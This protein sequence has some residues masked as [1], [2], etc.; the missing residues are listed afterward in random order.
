[1]KACF[2]ILALALAL[3]AAS[4]LQA[5]GLVA[6][7]SGKAYVKLSSKSTYQV[8]PV[9]AQLSNGTTVKV[10]PGSSVLLYCS[11][12]DQQTLTEAIQ[13]VTCASTASTLFS[14]GDRQLPAPRSKRR[15]LL[16]AATVLLDERPSI[17]WI[18]GTGTGSVRVMLRGSGMSWERVVAD[19]GELAYPSDAPPLQPGQA[20]RFLVLDPGE[21]PSLASGPL[22]SGVKVLS[23]S[24][25]NVLR[26]LL[27]QLA[28]DDNLSSA[29][30]IHVR[31]RTQL[32]AG[33]NAETI[34]LLEPAAKS[35][36]D[37]A[38]GAALLGRAWLQ[39]GCISCALPIL[40][41]AYQLSTESGEAYLA[42][43][44]GELLGL[45]YRQSGRLRDAL[46][47]EAALREASGQ[48]T[49]CSSAR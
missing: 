24:D 43:E 9:G 1:M 39:S 37:G 29:E 38:M 11:E 49:S 23:R 33:L 22:N 12:T 7:I 30:R 15:L 48:C 2:Y 5:A 21:D 13:I 8:L 27:A 14:W 45:A 10:D 44:S 19:T 28:A 34:W 42:I 25:A 26:K 31:A 17:R 3:P 35:E 46:D 32:L 4:D 40:K 16:P 41:K 18:P 36:S 47:V 20:Y 6:S